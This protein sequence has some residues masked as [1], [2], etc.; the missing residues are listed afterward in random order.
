MHTPQDEVRSAI[1]NAIQDYYGGHKLADSNPLIT[2]IMSLFTQQREALLG[3][4]EKPQPQEQVSGKQA[5][6]LCDACFEPIDLVTDEP[7]W[8]DNTPHHLKCFLRHYNRV[9][10]LKPSDGEV[11]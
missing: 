5:D 6:T 9:T 4:S 11:K 2:N 8:F 10:D 1:V 7:V 3:A